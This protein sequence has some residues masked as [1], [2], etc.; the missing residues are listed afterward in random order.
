MVEFN[1]Q[2]SRLVRQNYQAF[3]DFLLG[4]FDI[5][6]QQIDSLMVQFLHN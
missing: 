5:N 1:K 3:N 2:L 4:S 6:L